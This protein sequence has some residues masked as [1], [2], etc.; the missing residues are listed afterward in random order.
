MNW[1]DILL[2]L[3]LLVGL[4]RGLM[5]GFVTEVVA[6]LVVILGVLGAQG[7]AP[8]FAKWMVKQFAWQA[9]VCDIV[10]YV[11][12]FLAIAI[13]LAI[14]ARMLSKLLKA[15]HLGWANRLFGG[16]LGIGKYAILVLIA[17]FVMEKT[18]KSFHWIKKSEAVKTSIVYPYAVEAVHYAEDAFKKM[19]H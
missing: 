16:I 18:D 8:A 14:I 5:R 3:P 1:F 15:I 10:A 4:V 17:V 13:V 6:I 19:E 7:W 12:I 2:V 9:E 11:L